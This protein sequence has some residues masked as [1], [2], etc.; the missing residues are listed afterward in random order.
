[1]TTVKITQTDEGLLV[2]RVGNENVN[3]NDN[4]NENENEGRS[5]TRESVSAGGNSGKDE[6]LQPAEETEGA[7]ENGSDGD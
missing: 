6:T 2:E 3:D 4:E 5:D 1:M 7:T